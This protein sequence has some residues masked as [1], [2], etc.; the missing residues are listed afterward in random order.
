VLIPGWFHESLPAFIEQILGDS[1]ISLL[2]I[3]SDIYSSAITVLRGLRKNIV[4]ETVVIF[5]EL[6]N[7]PGYEE[8]E[9]K[10]LY[11]FC[12]ET[13]RGVEFVG[14]PGDPGYWKRTGV[15]NALYQQ[16]VL[17]II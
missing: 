12:R 3:D 14:C 9:L 16:V 8:H 11:D 17:R 6:I 2:H 5:D 15:D 1:R 4:P 10:A 13:N 7:Y